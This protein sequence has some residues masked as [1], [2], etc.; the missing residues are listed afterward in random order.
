MALVSSLAVISKMPRKL[1]SRTDN[2]CRQ[3]A[4][5]SSSQEK[6][7]IDRTSKRWHISHSAVSKGI[8]LSG[9]L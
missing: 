2:A 4:V 5:V 1:M 9:T 8:W 7:N 3:T 6:E